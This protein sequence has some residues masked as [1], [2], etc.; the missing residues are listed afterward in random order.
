MK[1]LKKVGFNVDRNGRRE[2]V[3]ENRLKKFGREDLIDKSYEISKYD[4]FLKL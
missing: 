1:H 3:I 4:Y 2:D